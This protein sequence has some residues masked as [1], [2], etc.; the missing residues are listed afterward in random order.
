MSKLITSCR[1]QFPDFDCI[2]GLLETA[3]P[4]GAGCRVRGNSL[5]YFCNFGRVLNRLQITGYVNS[6]NHNQLHQ[7][8]VL[9]PSR[10]LQREDRT[11]WPPLLGSRWGPRGLGPPG[12]A[13]PDTACRRP[14]R[15]SRASIR[16]TG[17]G[18]LCLSLRAA[19]G[20]WE[21]TAAESEMFFPAAFRG[22]E[23][24]KTQIKPETLLWYRPFKRK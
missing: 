18:G 6:N 9:S 13:Q 11:A 8:S 23:G 19:R 5:N 21:G 7:V 10:P 3:S 15:G 22:A 4:G 16:A 24:E 20:P 12:R 2:L 14:L 17:R 1:G